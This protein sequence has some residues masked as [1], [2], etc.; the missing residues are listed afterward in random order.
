MM[1]KVLSLKN[2]EFLILPQ[3]VS[4]TCSSLFKTL[5]FYSEQIDSLIIR[6]GTFIMLWNFNPYTEELL[7]SCS[8]KVS[9][10]LRL[11]TN[12]HAEKNI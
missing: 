2:T 7:K 4:K 11:S 1:K 12:I 6:I 5:I 3:F 10:Y 9:L 8:Y